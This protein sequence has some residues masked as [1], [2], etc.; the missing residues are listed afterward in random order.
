MN[1]SELSSVCLKNC[2][3]ITTS[4]FVSWHKT[5]ISWKASKEVRGT[6][7]RAMTTVHAKY[8]D[9]ERSGTPHESAVRAFY[10]IF[11]QNLFPGQFC[12]W[13][14]SVCVCGQPQQ[15]RPRA[16]NH[17]LDCRRNSN[18][19]IDSHISRNLRKHIFRK[20]RNIDSEFSR[21]CDIHAT[22]LT[23]MKGKYDPSHTVIPEFP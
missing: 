18:L 21:V 19:R 12:V 10:G 5:C 11:Y 1:D 14:V 7:S 4:P 6:R 16:G 13:I 9:D 20:N 22:T 3:S 17:A 15:S 8:A 23:K 2:S